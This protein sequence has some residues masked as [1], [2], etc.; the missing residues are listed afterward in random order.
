MP[1]RIVFFGLPLA[2]LLL[3]RDGHQIELCAVCRKDALGLRRATRTFGKERMWVRPRANDAAL[4]KRVRTIAPDLVV[5]WFWTTRLPMNIVET[6]RLGAIGVHPSLLPRH[7]G[8]DPTTWAIL[9]GD[10]VTGVTVHRIAAEYDTGAML[11]HETLR[12]DPA[13][14]AW[15]L[16]RALDRPSL[17]ALRRTVARFARGEPVPE[18]PQDEHLATEAPFL[19]EEACAIRWSWPNERIL[20]LI[21]ALA[22]APGA[23]TEI[24]GSLV[25]VHAAEPVMRFPA[26]LEPGEGY[27][28]AERAVVR[29]GDGAIALLRG[30]IEGQEAKAK[31]LCRLFFSD[32]PLL[33]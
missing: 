11:E 18:K 31:D 23:W 20:R 13:W 17:R 25:H 19:D 29:T 9:S 6:A 1:L 15:N 3:A 22:P 26:A 16:A 8:P 30:E 24:N 12:I 5:S 32:A 33:G 14:N 27:I 10:D 7:R 4:L 28:D 21:R 2:A